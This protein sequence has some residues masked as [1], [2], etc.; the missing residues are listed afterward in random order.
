MDLKTIK[1]SLTVRNDTI[2]S[3]LKDINKYPVLSADEENE[4]ISLIRENNEHS[5]EYRDKLISSNQRF[6]FAIAKRYCSDERVL[7]LVDEGNI[8]L[9]EAIDKYDPTVGVRF[10]SYAVWYIR[11]SINYYLIND[12]L[13]IKKS[14]NMK[15]GT[16]TS[17]I[18]N[19]FFCENGRY[20]SDNEI[21]DILKNEYDIDINN[22]IDVIEVKTNSINST[23]TEDN[24]SCTVENSSEFV[25]KTASYNDYEKQME[26]EHATKTVEHY[27]SFL[28]ERNATILKMSYGIGYNKEYTNYEIAEELGLSSER[29]RQLKT[30]S[31]QKLQKAAKYN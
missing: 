10:L 3:Y 24:T 29:V 23:L 17:T 30:E 28:N 1:G 19:K 18:E 31:M 8:G 22:K 27:L 2:N 7:D 15:L 9:M 20:P 4:L 6:V 11:R 25:D 16:K 21:I 5:K 26:K 14:N 12:N 13:M